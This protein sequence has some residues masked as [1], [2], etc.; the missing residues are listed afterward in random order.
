MRNDYNS[1]FF[2]HILDDD[3]DGDDEFFRIIIAFPPECERQ[4]NDNYAV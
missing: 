2:I 3:D 1:P 4:W